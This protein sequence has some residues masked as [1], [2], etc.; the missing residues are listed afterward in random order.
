MFVAIT[1]IVTA[2][3][4][5]T[6]DGVTVR[7]EMVNAAGFSSGCFVIVVGGLVVVGAVDVITGVA[8]VVVGGVVVCR[9]GEK[10][11]V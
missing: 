7:L 11:V 4:L 5:I 6:S 10:V 2:A 1:S 3:P 9:G 8:A